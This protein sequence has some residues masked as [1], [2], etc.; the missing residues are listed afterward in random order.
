MKE[1]FYDTEYEVVSVVRNKSTRNFKTKIK[2]LS[3]I[4][5][6]IKN[7]TPNTISYKSNFT[8]EE[9]SA[10]QSLKENQDIVFEQERKEVDGL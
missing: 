9:Y 10:L 1:I 6:E 4:I 8:Q 5:N 2:E 7:L 3:L